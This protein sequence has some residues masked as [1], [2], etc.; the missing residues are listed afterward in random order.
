MVTENNSIYVKMVDG[1]TISEDQVQRRLETKKYWKSIWKK[2]VIHDTNAQGLVE[3]TAD[4][5][6][7]LDQDPVTIRV[8]DSHD[9]L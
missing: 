9:T 8:A 3:I 6:N 2:D 5:S 4:H 7:I 1:N